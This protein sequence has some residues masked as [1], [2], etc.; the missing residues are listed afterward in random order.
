MYRTKNKLSKSMKPAKIKKL[1][2]EFYVGTK[3]WQYK[4]QLTSTDALSA[5]VNNCFS[6]IYGLLS[7]QKHISIH[8]SPHQIII[9]FMC[10]IMKHNNLFYSFVHLRRK[11]SENDD[12]NTI[13]YKVI[14]D[15]DLFIPE[16]VWYNETEEVFYFNNRLI[17]TCLSYANQKI[18]LDFPT[19]LIDHRVNFDYHSTQSDTMNIDSSILPEM[20]M[21]FMIAEHAVLHLPQKNPDYI[22]HEK[23]KKSNLFMFHTMITFRM[24]GDIESILKKT[25]GDDN[26]LS[27]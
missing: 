24:V 23:S 22:N 10:A 14:E 18:V 9:Q 19:D 6:L 27:I 8:N 4:E 16:C 11:V 12:I 13:K 2:K 1:N 25:I 17:K 3:R 7:R 15:V 21:L 20:C 26:I 5:Y